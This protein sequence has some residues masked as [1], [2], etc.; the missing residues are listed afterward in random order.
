M[1]VREEK[2]I[3]ER[4]SANGEVIFLALYE[5]RTHGDGDIGPQ[6]QR[7]KGLCIIDEQI[8]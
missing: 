2:W 5:V 7:N 1:S 4:W 8:T 6:I 3:L